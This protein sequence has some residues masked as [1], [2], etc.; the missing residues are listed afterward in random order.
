MTKVKNNDIEF[1]STDAQGALLVIYRR[2]IFFI[3]MTTPQ[4]QVL[5]KAN[6]DL[7]PPARPNRHSFYSQ[8]F[9]TLL[10]ELHDVDHN[11]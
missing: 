3:L 5:D 9:N 4:R 2:W 8:R 7:R 10:D 6:W 1:D 11:V